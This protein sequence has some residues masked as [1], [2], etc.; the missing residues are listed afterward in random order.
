MKL[1]IV[2][3]RRSGTT[4]TFDS[5]C[6]DDRVQWAYEPFALAPEWARLGGGSGARPVNYAATTRRLRREWVEAAG[7]R[8]AGRSLEFNQ[9]APQY[10]ELEA[11]SQ[12]DEPYLEFLEYLF[13]RGPD[14]VVKSVRLH[15]RLASVVERLPDVKVLHVVRDPAS[16][17]WSHASLRRL[18]RPLRESWLDRWRVRRA[19]RSPK[20]FDGWAS[21]RLFEALNSR[22]AG[23]QY[24]QSAAERT[25][26]LWARVFTRV[27]EV[28][29]TL[30][31]DRYTILSHERF[32]SA[33]A[34]ALTQIYE[35]AGQSVS[36]QA[37]SWVERHVRPSRGA[38]DGLAGP[39]RDLVAQWSEP[40]GLE[41]IRQRIVEAGLL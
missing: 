40:L 39:F 25:L 4:I 21:V 41:R 33:P 1:L 38:P 37:R 14:V 32:C 3:M 34:S 8:W 18:P 23:L 36:D 9:G 11:R 19:L 30:D 20:G 15:H 26:W 10:P 28:G 29:M 6:E 12:L 13:N 16:V 27:D 7:D 2:G 24:I 17:L 35:W 5:L 22:D 31:P